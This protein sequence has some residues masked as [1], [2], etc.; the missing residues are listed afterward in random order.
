MMSVKAAVQCRS[1]Q[2]PAATHQV[3]AGHVASQLDTLVVELCLPRWHSVLGQGA[4][5]G[6]HC[7]EAKKNKEYFWS[8]EIKMTHAWTDTKSQ[9][10]KLDFTKVIKVCMGGTSTINKSYTVSSSEIQTSPDKTLRSIFHSWSP[11]VST[12]RDVVEGPVQNQVREKAE[13]KMWAR[14]WTE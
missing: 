10:Y 9:I 2:W 11:P 4:G 12:K 6:H 8:S 14:K 3:L 5:H 13:L 1:S 7:S